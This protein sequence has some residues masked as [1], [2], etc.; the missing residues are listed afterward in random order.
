MHAVSLR[1][2]ADLAGFRQAV[3]SLVARGVAPENA[4][5]TVDDAPALFASHRRS[6]A[7]QASPEPIHA[8]VV[9]PGGDREVS[10]SS[11]A[12][13]GSGLSPRSPRNDRAGDLLASVS[14]PRAEPLTPAPLPPGEGTPLLLPRAV[15]E[16]VASVVCH[17]DPERYALLYGLIRRVLQGER[18][19]IDIPSDPLV[20]RLDMMRRAVKRDLH[21]MHGFLRFRKVE[22]DGRDH[23]VA[24]FE[25]EHFILEA[26]AE[27][28]VERFASLHWSILTPI[29]SLHWN[30]ERLAFGPPGRRSD[31]PEHDAFEGGWRDYYESTFNPARTNPRAMRAE[32]PKKYWKNMPETASIQRL[33]QTAPARVS[34]MLGKE[35]TVP[36]K[37]TPEAALAQMRDQE[38][39]SLEE[40]NALLLA[41]DPLVPGATRAV[42]GEG[43]ADARIV[44]VGEQPG[45]Q[46]DQQGR[47]FVGPAGKL[48]DRALE[49]AGLERRKVYLTNAVK[50]FKFEE[51]GKRR[52]HQKPTAGEVK[53]YR[54]WLEK[55][56]ELIRPQLVVA[57]GG[58]A[59]L[60]MTGKSLPI[61]RARG[62]MPF[63]DGYSGYV[64]VHPSYL[65]RLPDE[66]A[67]ASAYRQFVG[68]LEAVRSLAQS[69]G[70]G[71]RAAQAAG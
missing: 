21:K 54:W 16:L 61:T 53:H 34:E 57:L 33:I 25:P 65:L 22:H 14:P 13:M 48:L 58:T 45:D 4:V 46:E 9:E 51:R 63:P 27:F 67:K 15:H 55:E 19:L 28:F 39:K 35:A 20:H 70:E 10:S 37:R 7:P 6:G 68:D 17:R 71:R 62:P 18:A 66:E 26:A 32:M 64:T 52:I 2:G 3:R 60:A 59:V 5:F 1:P 56:L 29:G 43:P 23:F 11:T 12:F 47:A 40:L 50:H 31:A 42:P 24:W 44:F 36:T 41:S 69:P 30:R 38:V 8:N 49:E